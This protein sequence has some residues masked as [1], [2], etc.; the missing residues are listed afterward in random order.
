MAALTKNAISVTVRDG[1][2][3]T[4]IWDH[5]GYKSLITNIFKKFKI[6]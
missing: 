4:K 1:A 6:L 5:Q 3:R 2:K